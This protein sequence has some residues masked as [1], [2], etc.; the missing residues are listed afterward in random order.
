VSIPDEGLYY[1]HFA[2]VLPVVGEEL[3]N[4]RVALWGLPAGAPL[5]H[6]L[7]GCGI[8]Q[9]LV[10]APDANGFDSIAAALQAQ[11]GAALALA[12]DGVP[13]G[14]WQ[15][16]LADWQPHLVIVVDGP[17]AGMPPLDAPLLQVVRPR[18]GSGC[19]LQVTLPGR[20]Q[21][22]LKVQAGP[23]DYWEWATAA[24]LCA[25]VARALLMRNGPSARGDLAHWW[26][27]GCAHV[28]VGGTQPLRARWFMGHS[29]TG[30]VPASASAPQRYVTP[31]AR[32]GRLLVV[33]LGTLGS[34]A[35][36]P[37]AKLCRQMVVVDDDLVAAANPVRQAYPLSSIGQP[38]ATELAMLLHRRS[39][40]LVTPV[41]SR[42]NSEEQVQRLV[43]EHAIDV[44]LVA[45]GTNADFA[46]ARALHASGVSHVVGRCYPRGRYWE[47]I[48]VDGNRGV[49]Y[50]A[51]RG[52]VEVGPAAAPTVEELAAY[53]EAGAL[54]AEP[55][56]VVEC[57]WAA[58]WLARLTAQLLAPQGLRE[59]W[60]LA[61][62]AAEA[63]CLV[64][65]IMVEQTAAGP[66][67]QIRAPGEV[68]AW[69][70]A[71]VQEA[72]A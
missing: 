55:A 39:A 30:P 22:E 68:H 3:R 34:L 61:L 1:E 41:V 24:P 9:W 65:G 44:A 6:Y 51:L 46:I 5:V 49:P 56:T 43:Q 62:L 45:T 63:T 14:F 11:H 17:A 21:Q 42:L 38:K 47:G 29:V 8:G 32:R 72:Q 2:R 20:Q 52:Q 50:A 57:G 36:Q 64:G 58:M 35:A 25:S 4:R 18:S 67:Y 53:S 15:V 60:L 13:D 26:A 59:R 48:L 31:P 23:L 16:R 19:M 27:G 54:E 66:A 7:A 12:W 71:Q 40:C 69:R 33:G 10:Q 37:L 28:V 70:R